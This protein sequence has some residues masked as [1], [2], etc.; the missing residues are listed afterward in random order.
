MKV[1]FSGYACR[2]VF[3]SY[4]NKNVAISLVA[5]NPENIGCLMDGEPIARATLNCGELDYGLVAIKDYSENHGMVR[6]LLDA[7]VIEGERIHADPKLDAFPI[8]RLSSESIGII[9]RQGID[10]SR[11]TPA[12]S[13]LELVNA[14]ARMNIW[15]YDND[16]GDDYAECDEPSEGF[17]DSHCALMSLIEQSRKIA[18]AHNG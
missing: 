17:L 10:I 18:G 12:E 16:K 11:L 14:I 1:E 5:D 3:A 4:K 8:Y 2:A 7:G 13:A 6:A 9:K 15:S